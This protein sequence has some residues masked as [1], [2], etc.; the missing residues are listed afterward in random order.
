MHDQEICVL[1]VQSSWAVQIGWNSEKKHFLGGVMTKQ[2]S[3][4]KLTAWLCGWR[5]SSVG[6]PTTLA[7][8]EIDWKKHHMNCHEILYRPSWAPEDES[9]WLWLA[10]S[11][12]LMDYHA[13]RSRHSWSLNFGN[14]Q[15]FHLA[16][17]SGQNFNLPNTLVHLTIWFSC[18]AV[19]L[20]PRACIK[21]FVKVKTKSLCQLSNNLKC[22]EICYL[23][24]QPTLYNAKV[25]T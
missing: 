15:T 22:V 5:C 1:Q 10:M 11:W 2:Q 4:A 14:P 23:G 6:L 9:C 16:P 25:I 3:L 17:S 12:Q 8:T 18:L 19:D 13:I 7:Q 20:D 21:L 24:S